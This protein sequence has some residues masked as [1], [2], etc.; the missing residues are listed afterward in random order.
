MRV[1][2]FLLRFRS[3]H[4][5][6]SVAEKPAELFEESPKVVEE[7]HQ[8]ETPEVSPE[9]KPQL[10]VLGDIRKLEELLESQAGVGKAQASFKTAKDGTQLLQILIISK[11]RGIRSK[12]K[13]KLIDR[14][15][16]VVVPRIDMPKE[17]IS[18]TVQRAPK[19]ISIS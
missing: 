16:N 6:G 12:Q 17:Q 18:F 19:G 3:F 9:E 13:M 10:R 11:N 2:T 8:A 5:N 7:T 4:R 15:T 14:L 1:V